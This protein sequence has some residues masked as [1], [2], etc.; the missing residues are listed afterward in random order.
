MDADSRGWKGDEIRRLEIGNGILPCRS[1]NMDEMA[2]ISSKSAFIRDS[3][4]LFW[5]RWATSTTAKSMQGHLIAIAHNLMLL[6]SEAL[7]S[8]HQIEDVVELKRRKI[9]RKREQESGRKR[10]FVDGLSIWLQRATQRGVKFIRWLRAQL[11][12]PASWEQACA[13]LTA[14]Y[15]RL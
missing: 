8:E 5:A 6:L 15:A 1:P 2:T 7:K 9:R 13:S 11:R 3:F 12:R 14:L 10:K 4:R